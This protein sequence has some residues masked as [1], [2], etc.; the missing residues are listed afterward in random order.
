MPV[1]GSG[2]P[3]GSEV[4]LADQ[5]GLVDVTALHVTGELLKL[6]CAPFSLVLRVGELEH[7]LPKLLLD[8]VTSCS[9]LEMYPSSNK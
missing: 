2:R 6:T 3:V 1:P 5:R 9:L 8:H 4:A 7:K